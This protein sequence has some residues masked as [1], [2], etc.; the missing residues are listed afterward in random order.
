MAKIDFKEF[1]KQY[2]PKITY[3]RH[4]TNIGLSVLQLSAMEQSSFLF[5]PKLDYSGNLV[6]KE[7]QQSRE[8]LLI[9]DALMF[10]SAGEKIFVEADN[11]TERKNTSLV[12]KIGKYASLLAL[13]PKESF[14]TTIHFSVW[15]KRMENEWE[16]EFYGLQ[17]VSELHYFIYEELN[18]DVTFY[19]LVEI[20]YEYSGGY[21]PAIQA[22]KYLKEIGEEG[23]CE[24]VSLNELKEAAERKHLYDWFDKYFV[25]RQRYIYQAVKRNTL[26]CAWLQKGARLVCL[27]VYISKRILDCVY[28]GHVKKEII[29]SFLK[30][31]GYLFD[32]CEY[33]PEGKEFQDRSGEIY[34][35]KNLFCLTSA[36]SETKRYVAIEN[37]SDEYGGAL[38]V[39]KYAGLHR[40]IDEE[41][42][43]ICLYNKGTMED[44]M[45]LFDCS[46]GVKQRC[47]IQFAS[48]EQFLG[49][50]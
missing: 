16:S 19:E 18:F 33:L 17:N 26:F 15:H 1:K 44:P 22:A 43:I 12:P 8:C 42:D 35:F 38:R 34:V 31:E 7:Y 20:L 48:Y 9:P 36:E 28:I 4:Q 40:K 25:N 39:R 6:K 30:N 45:R 27:P 37:I 23:T 14:D 46:D 2:S 21:K 5:E 3:L 41:L 11:C 13:E 47:H 24:Y 10:S 49:L 29:V 50:E 32:I